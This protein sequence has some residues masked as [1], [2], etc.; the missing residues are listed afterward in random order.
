[1]Y[2]VLSYAKWIAHLLCGRRSIDRTTL[3]LCVFW[4]ISRCLLTRGLS[5]YA[6][7]ASALHLLIYGPNTFKE[8]NVFIQITRFKYFAGIH[9]YI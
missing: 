9:I 6:L 7:L 5:I 1:M 3:N 8:F 4:Y 2:F